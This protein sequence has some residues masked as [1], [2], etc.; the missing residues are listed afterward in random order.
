[1]QRD[2][3]G[4]GSSRGLEFW[5]SSNDMESDTEEEGNAKDI[6]IAYRPQAWNK[7]YASYDPQF[8]PSRQGNIGLTQQYDSIPSY[9]ELFKKFWSHETLTKICREDN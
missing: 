2:D 8:M 1:M 5:Y 9:A 3:A 6:K 4:A 7:Q